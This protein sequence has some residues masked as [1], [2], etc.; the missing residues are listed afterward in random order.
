MLILDRVANFFV[1]WLS[2]FFSLAGAEQP[3]VFIL[4]ADDLGYKDI[5]WSVVI[6]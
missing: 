5:G 6:H 1:L 3:N 4:L 2:F